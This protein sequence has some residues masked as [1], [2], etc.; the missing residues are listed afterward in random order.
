M[1][2]EK[3]LREEA[4]KEKDELQQRMQE[5]QEQFHATQEAM[6]CQSENSV[7][8]LHNVQKCA[9]FIFLITPSK[10]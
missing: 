6:V 9:H 2:R 1:L 10:C 5:L 3:Q 4:Q 8:K 7:E